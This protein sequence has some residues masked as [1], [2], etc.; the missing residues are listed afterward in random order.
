MDP[1]TFVIAIM[2]CADSG[3]MCQTARVEPATYPTAAACQAAMGPALRRNTDISA[4]IIQAS[5]QRQTPGL[6]KLQKK[7]ARERG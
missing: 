4:P 2:G 1:L 6:V 7:T 5:C 3:R